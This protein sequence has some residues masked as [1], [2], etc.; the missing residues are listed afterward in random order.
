MFFRVAVFKNSKV[1]QGNIVGGAG[2]RVLKK[3]SLK[4][5]SWVLDD[6][7]QLKAL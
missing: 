4:A 7:W 5:N 3:A 6:S 2:L 1:S